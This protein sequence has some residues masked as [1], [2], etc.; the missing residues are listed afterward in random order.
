[1]KSW[2]TG[3]DP[4][5][6]KDWEQEEKGVTENEMIGRHHW[7]KGHEFEQTPRDSG[8]Q[9][10]LAC[11]SPWSGKESDKTEQLNKNNKQKRELNR[12]GRP[13]RRGC[14]HTLW[15]Q[16]RPAVRR[17]TPFLERT[18]PVKNQRLWSQN[19]S[20]L[21]SWMRPS[22]LA[23]RGLTCEFPL[24][25]TPESQFSA[26]PENTRFYW[27]KT[28][29]SICFRS[30]VLEGVEYWDWEYKGLYWGLPGPYYSRNNLALEKW[31][32]ADFL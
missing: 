13:S 11:W 2:P 26:D 16:Q 7:L 30:T 1:M 9:G 22:S 31:I 29:Q 25:Q 8:G 24:L 28:L 14:F 4:G 18:Q 21:P 12:V 32:T 20:H 6:E 10:S 15:G 27:R 17:K 23:M 3:K 5:A 19:P